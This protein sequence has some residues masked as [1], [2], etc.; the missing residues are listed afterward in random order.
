MAIIAGSLE[1]GTGLPSRHIRTLAMALA[2]L[3]LLW[4]IRTA[5]LF[6][7][8]YESGFSVVNP[9]KAPAAGAAPPSSGVPNNHNNNH[10]PIVNGPPPVALPG[11]DF[12][13]TDALHNALNPPPPPPPPPPPVRAFPDSVAVLMETDVTRVANLVPV[14][15]HFVNLLGPK[16]PV[17]VL[18]LRSTWVEPASPVFK[19]YM[20]EQ[21]IRIHFLPEDTTFPDHSDVSV[22]FTKP[23]LWEQFESAD[24]VLLFQADSIL[25]S[26]SAA[27]IDDFMEWDLLGAPI[28][29][30]F[31]VGYNGG[32]SLRNPKLMLELTRNPDINDFET[33]LRAYQAEQEVLKATEGDEKADEEARKTPSWDKFEDQWFFHAL[34]THKP[35]AKLP[36][37]DVA[38]TFS[39]E[40][41]WYDTP[42]GYH[43]PFRWLTDSQKKKVL[44]YCPEVAL[45]QDGSHFF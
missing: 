40:T 20:A 8:H 43:Q 26:K 21:R 30:R 29:S 31:G 35:E 12:Y 22:F 32:L 39:V 23:W 7:P 25:C 42:L 2:I 45:L 9:S 17:V 36:S 4:V 1:N 14:V 33:N 13:I 11:D 41:V 27:R 18:T 24:R 19:R 37:Q 10:Q 34:E 28:A 15:L 44:E 16:W 5:G 3:T 6:H 38:R